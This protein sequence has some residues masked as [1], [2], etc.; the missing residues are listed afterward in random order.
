MKRIILAALLVLC[1]SGCLSDLDRKQAVMRD[2]QRD[3]DLSFAGLSTRYAETAEE[4]A[5]KKHELQDQTISSEWAEFLRRHTDDSG[6]LVSRDA[7]GNLVP[8]ALADL[9]LAMERVNEKKATLADS[10]RSWDRVHSQYL[11]AIGQYSA[12]TKQSAETDE[13]YMAAKASAQQVVDTAVGLV[14]GVA[15]GAVIVP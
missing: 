4:M 14:A 9:Q 3:A 8:M 15:A 12:M 6:R 10:R 1:A 5:A 7:E 13:E 11:V 2:K